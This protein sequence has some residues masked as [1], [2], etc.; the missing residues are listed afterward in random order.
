VGIVEQKKKYISKAAQARARTSSWRARP[1]LDET[2][3]S[4]IRGRTV[5]VV[6][7]PVFAQ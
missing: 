3:R 6:A 5:A 4:A 2:V 1:F 7:M